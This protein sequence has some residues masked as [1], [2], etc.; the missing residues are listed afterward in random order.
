MTHGFKK[1][2]AAAA[3][4]ALAAS[5]AQAKFWGEKQQGADVDPRGGA[6]ITHWC[7][8]VFWIKTSCYCRLPDGTKFDCGE[9]RN[10]VGTR[11]RDSKAEDKAMKGPDHTR[12]QANRTPRP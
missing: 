1:A 7:Y 8:Y 12:P 2:F 3:L 4:I 6:P 9:V 5:P 10:S 11:I